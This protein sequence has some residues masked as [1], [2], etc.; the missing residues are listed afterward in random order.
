[1]NSEKLEILQEKMKS[2]YAWSYQTTMFASE[3]INFK[4][5]SELNTLHTGRKAF[6]LLDSQEEVF[7]RYQKF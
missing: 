2:A 6:L 1:M 4:T 7:L 5:L 3:L